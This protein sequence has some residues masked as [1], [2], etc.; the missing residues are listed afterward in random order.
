MEHH[1]RSHLK[2][3]NHQCELCAQMFY[4]PSALKEH[5][6]IHRGE[7]NFKCDECGKSYPGLKSLQCHKKSHKRKL[8][9]RSC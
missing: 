1:R 5:M 9:R 6:A 8:V 2:V 7:R 3:F 4:V